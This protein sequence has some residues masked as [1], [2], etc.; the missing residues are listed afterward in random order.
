MEPWERLIATVII[1]VRSFSN[2]MWREY[3]YLVDSE[4]PVLHWPV[5]CEG[6]REEVGEPRLLPLKRERKEREEGERPGDAPKEGL[7][8]HLVGLEPVCRLKVHGVKFFFA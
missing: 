1:A 6:R 5:E 8:C 4:D 7:P 2:N 3:T